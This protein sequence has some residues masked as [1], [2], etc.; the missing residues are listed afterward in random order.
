[1]GISYKESFETI[2]Y[3]KL[4]TVGQTAVHLVA[5]LGSYALAGEFGL[6]QSAASIE[7]PA[8]A[9]HIGLT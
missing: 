5:K 6:R 1:M 7:I 2:D 4:N 8:I 9:L 3:T